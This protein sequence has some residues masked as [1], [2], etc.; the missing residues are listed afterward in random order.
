[1]SY[2]IIMPPKGHSL[3][4]RYILDNE[5]FMFEDDLPEMN[6]VEYKEWLK[7]SFVDGVR[8]GYKVELTGKE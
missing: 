5:S 3:S 4:D 6:D 1:M 8:Y 2:K 7:Y